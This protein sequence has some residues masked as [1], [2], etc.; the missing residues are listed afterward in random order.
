MAMSV[1][2]TA[3]RQ[4][5]HR[6]F[7]TRLGGRSRGGGNALSS[8]DFSLVRCP[9]IQNLHSREDPPASAVALSAVIA[10]NGASRVPWERRK[11][12]VDIYDQS[13]NVSVGDNQAYVHELAA[14]V[15]TKMRE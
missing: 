7:A 2:R 10:Q 1:E 3:Q 12:K 13:Y 9:V 8:T 11:M 14:Y 15:D 6:Q 5:H 4:S